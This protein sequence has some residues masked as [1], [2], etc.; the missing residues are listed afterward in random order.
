M[1]ATGGRGR[2]GG[3]RGG[4]RGRSQRF[5]RAGR[6]DA[7]GR[8]PAAG[9]D[10]PPSKY[11]S[12]RPIRTAPI[13]A[14]RTA[15]ETARRI[16]SRSSCRASRS[17]NTKI[18]LR[19]AA[20]AAP[21]AEHSSVRG[22]KRRAAQLPS[23]RVHAR[24]QYPRVPG[25]L[26]AVPPRRSAEAARCRTDRVARGSH[27]RNRRPRAEIRGAAWTP[28]APRSTPR[29]I[30]RITQAGMARE[31]SED[32]ATALRRAARTTQA[33]GSQTDA[34]RPRRSRAAV[35]ESSVEPAEA[36]QS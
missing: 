24:Q 18:A 12:P 3:G 36:H 16:S 8:S 4:P 1:T 22:A 17:P 5:G 23:P 2:C 15:G 6:E 28:P 27:A 7:A 19:A 30:W 21:R 20:P 33:R 14:L 13:A 11:A 32:D 31:L 10:L 26:S 34:E 29:P 9:R 35:A 25:A